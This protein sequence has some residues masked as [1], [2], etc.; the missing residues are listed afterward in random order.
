MEEERDLGVI[1]SLDLK[2]TKMCRK[3]VDTANRALKIEHLHIELQ[4]FCCPYIA[5]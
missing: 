2:V 5:W 3:V 1:I 4:K